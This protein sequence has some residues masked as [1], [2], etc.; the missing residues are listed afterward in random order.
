MPTN[1][2]KLSFMN[3]VIKDDYMYLHVDLNFETN[4]H[5]VLFDFCF[6]IRNNSNN[7][8]CHCVKKPFTSKKNESIFKST[9]SRPM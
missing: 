4:L 2:E 7:I 1:R 8:N 6:G 3:H 9:I 5:I